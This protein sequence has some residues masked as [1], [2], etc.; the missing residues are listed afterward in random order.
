MIDN[1][2]AVPIYKQIVQSVCGAIDR[3]ELVQNDRLPSVNS[4]AEKFSLA[5]GS[6]F[7]AYNE[8]RA[9][10][11][12]DSIPGKGYFVTST[13]TKLT[14]TI[15]L[16][17]SKFDAASQ[18]IY[19]S[20]MNHLPGNCKVRTFFYNQV[21][22]DFESIIKEEAPYFNTYVIVPGTGT[23]TGDVLSGLDQK[24]VILLDAGF[25]E[26]S[27]QFA[28]V[29][30][31]AEKELFNMLTKHKNSLQKYKRLFLLVPGAM[32][33]KDVVSGFKKFAKTTDLPCEVLHAADAGS[34]RKGD[35]FIVS[36][37]HHLVELVTAIKANDWRLGKDIGILSL[38]ECALKSAIEDGISTLSTDYH[39]MGR[40]VG[41]ML[42]ANDRRVIE[43]SFVFTDRKSF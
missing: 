14:Q 28:G 23:N 33:A 20:L 36:D 1:S 16:L 19:Q 34:I 22:T 41:E 24:Q 26:F 6:V 4:I 32:G 43:N 7:S 11:I 35:A 21:Q 27:K 38:N 29:Y 25:R 12:I 18:M 15:F 30:R 2:L 37:D 42:S 5:R 17:F 3:G 8:L 39:A 31:N 10:G 40:Q 13:Q 9:S